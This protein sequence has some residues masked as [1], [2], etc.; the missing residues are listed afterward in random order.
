ME[1]ETK[2]PGASDSANTVGV[3]VVMFGLAAT[4]V[5]TCIPAGAPQEI[6]RLGY[7]CVFAMATMILVF[8]GERRREA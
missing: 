2:K 4:V 6:A 8:W 7:I 5:F 1:T 3:S